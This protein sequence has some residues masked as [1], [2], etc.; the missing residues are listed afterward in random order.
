MMRAMGLPVAFDTTAGKKVE[1]NQGVGKAERKTIRKHRQF[2]NRA[3]SFTADGR[4][5][6]SLG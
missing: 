5:W 6:P 4:T 2:M 1:S 3:K